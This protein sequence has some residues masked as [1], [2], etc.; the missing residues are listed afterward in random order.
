MQFVHVQELTPCPSLG[1]RGELFSPFSFVRE[2]G[3]GDEFE[4]TP[5]TYQNTEIGK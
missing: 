5:I 4:Y 3:W 2:G 1:K